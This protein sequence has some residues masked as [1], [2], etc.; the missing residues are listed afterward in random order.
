MKVSINSIA[1]QYRIVGILPDC[2]FIDQSLYGQVLDFIS[3]F[4][5]TCVRMSLLNVLSYL[6]LKYA[7]C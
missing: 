1:E 4:L 7:H 5:S 2:N 6:I 3:A